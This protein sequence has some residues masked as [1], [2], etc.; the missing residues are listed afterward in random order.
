MFSTST[1]VKTRQF[2]LCVIMKWSTSHLGH[3]FQHT[4]SHNW[5]HYLS[6]YSVLNSFVQLSKLFLNPI[7]CF[8]YFSLEQFVFEYNQK[9]NT[10]N[11]A[12]NCLLSA[13]LKCQTKRTEVLSM[14]IFHTFIYCKGIDK[15][16]SSWSTYKHNKLN[17]K[18]SISYKESKHSVLSCPTVGERGI[19]FI[20]LWN[21]VDILWTVP[22]TQ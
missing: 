3:P 20:W 13:L 14:Y 19:Y 2:K 21:N 22:H 7:L 4:K 6:M 9:K 8:I 16:H 17:R 12:Q 11:T 15:K 1:R 18:R 5:W 10:P